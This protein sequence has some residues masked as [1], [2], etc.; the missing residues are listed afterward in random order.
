MKTIYLVDHIETVRAAALKRNEPGYNY[1]PE[2]IDKAIQAHIG[3]ELRYNLSTGI[4]YNKSLGWCSKFVNQEDI[5][6]YDSHD[7]AAEWSFTGM[8]RSSCSSFL[9]GYALI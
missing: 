6:V 8:V 1:S 7:D 2:L 5:P 9:R 3:D 4:T